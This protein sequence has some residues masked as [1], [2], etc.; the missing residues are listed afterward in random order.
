MKKQRGLTPPL[1][2][3]HRL[4]SDQWTPP[5]S[6]HECMEPWMF[7]ALVSGHAS[8][9]ER[10]V[11]QHAIEEC[12]LCKR[13]WSDWKRQ[14]GK[15]LKRPPSSSKDVVS[16][17]EAL[18]KKLASHSS[19]GSFFR[20]LANLRT[21]TWGLAVAAGIALFWNVA[22]LMPELSTNNSQGLRAK[23]HPPSRRTT[24]KG[25]KPVV[26]V[27]LYRKQ[28][29][30]IQSCGSSLQIQSGDEV[31]FSYRLMASR[32]YHALVFGS[33][34]KGKVVPLYPTQ[35]SKTYRWSP[36][37]KRDVFLPG[38][39]V[40]EPSAF[41]ERLYVCLSAQPIAYSFVKKQLRQGLQS[42]SIDR[43]ERLPLPCV[44][45]KSWLLRAP[46]GQQT[47]GAQRE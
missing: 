33:D 27:K 15:A 3:R 5:S 42:Q 43:L 9:E 1:S 22:A 23:G 45:Q 31:R 13:Q 44:Y 10:R 7:A 39:I 46:K 41:N 8:S 47:K 2:Q 4:Q 20:K 26:V 19:R 35:T 17:G 34:T 14:H 18:Q 12:S 24:R 28:G 36:T 16:Q 21:L 6:E 25:K 32:S 40:L 30:D 11:W 37:G 29:S 38:G